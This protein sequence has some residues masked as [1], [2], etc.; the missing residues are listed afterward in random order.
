M[1]NS[2]NTAFNALYYP[3]GDTFPKDLYNE[4]DLTQP[5]LN[6]SVVSTDIAPREYSKILKSLYYSTYLSYKSSNE[7]LDL[8]TKIE[9]G[10]GLRSNI[11]NE[12]KI[13]HKIGIKS[14][15]PNP[16]LNFTSDCGIVYVPK[17]PYIL[18][19]MSQEDNETAVKY[20]KTISS[21]IY[22]FIIKKEIKY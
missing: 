17:R 3:A 18:C 5:K 12:I 4:L 15:N 7:I 8:M 22:D 11:P 2:D 1:V 9:N 19:M 16:E 21:T 13:A 6:D 14:S 10:E 20:M